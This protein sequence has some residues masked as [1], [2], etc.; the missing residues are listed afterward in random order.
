[1]KRRRRS[2]QDRAA[3]PRTHFH[4]G[5]AFYCSGFPCNYNISIGMR[6]QPSISGEFSANRNSARGPSGQTCRPVRA[7]AGSTRHASSHPTAASERTNESKCRQTCEPLSNLMQMEIDRAVNAFVPHILPLIS[8]IA[9]P[10]S[11]LSPSDISRWE[12]FSA[13]R[14]CRAYDR[15]IKRSINHFQRCSFR[16]LFFRMRGDL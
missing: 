13:R 11:L 4:C 15:E 2:D 6:A 16:L 10:L 9:A 7:V 3:A 5:R 8:P 1:M 12:I 14:F